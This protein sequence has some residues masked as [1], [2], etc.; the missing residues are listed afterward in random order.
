MVVVEI[1]RA[2]NLSLGSVY[3]IIIRKFI[4]SALVVVC[5]G[6]ALMGHT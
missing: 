2:G 5:R 3:F 6:K 4:R 1:E